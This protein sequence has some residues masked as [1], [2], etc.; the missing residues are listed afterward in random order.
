VFTFVKL[1]PH[2]YP[3]ETKDKKEKEEK[4]EIVLPEERQRSGRILTSNKEGE[5]KRNYQ[6]AKRAPPTDPRHPPSQ[7]PHPP[8]QPPPHPD[9]LEEEQKAVI[10]A[11]RYSPSS[12]CQLVRSA[13]KN[14][15]IMDNTC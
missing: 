7:P 8:S 10:E 15:L 3:T 9:S 14:T 13:E 4:I 2:R 11:C 1:H 6:E 12:L 5:N